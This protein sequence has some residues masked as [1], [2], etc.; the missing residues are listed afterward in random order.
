M[1]PDLLKTGRALK[2]LS[3]LK[4]RAENDNLPNGMVVVELEINSEEGSLP[5]KTPISIENYRLYKGS[6]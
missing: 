1:K 5:I 2:K 3:I 4:F 6:N